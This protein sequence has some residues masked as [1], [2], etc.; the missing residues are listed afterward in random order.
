MTSTFF[1]EADYRDSGCG[2]AIERLVDDFGFR[3]PGIAT[4]EHVYFYAVGA[5]DAETRRFYLQRAYR[6]GH[7]FET[8]RSDGRN[9]EQREVPKISA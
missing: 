5:V 3:Y 8:A 2:Q 9:R 6:L 4:V 7:E 1:T